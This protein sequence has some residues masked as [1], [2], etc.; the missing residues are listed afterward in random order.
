[1]VPVKGE[2]MS[3]R[4]LAAIGAFLVLWASGC[5]SGPELEKYPRRE[6]DRPFTL[7]KGVA[8][9]HIPTIITEVSDSDSSEF[10]AIPVPL[11]WEQSL[12]DDWELIWAPIPL[13]VAHQLVNDSEDRL[14][15]TFFA[16]FSYSTVQKFRLIPTIAL[17]WR[18]RFSSDWALDLRPSFT[19]DISFESG[20]SF[21]WSAGL[22]IGPVWQASE[23]FALQP[24]IG[25][26]VAKGRTV[27]SDANDFDAI[28]FT[29]QTSFS[30]SVGVGSTWS[31]SRQWDFRP[32]YHF[33]WFTGDNGINAHVGIL[34]FVH[35][36]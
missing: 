31:I 9:W 8:T 11:I 17:S 19:P 1:M 2:T 26:G 35:F 14:G 13:G 21:R 10:L 34:E 5:A 12:S 16:G 27:L 22:S 30:A 25:L 33:G 15:M 32:S 3:T 28:D 4:I 36:W 29:D 6:I 20:R 7:P 24:T 18:R 23:I